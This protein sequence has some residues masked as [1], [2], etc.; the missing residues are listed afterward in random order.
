MI[1]HDYGFG[2]HAAMDVERSCQCA[3]LQHDPEGIGAPLRC[4][5]REGHDGLHDASIVRCH[6]CALPVRPTEDRE[7]GFAEDDGSRAV[8]H[9]SCFDAAAKENW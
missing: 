7:L 3:A 8:W 6:G 2:G 9:K 5:L 1:V 4:G